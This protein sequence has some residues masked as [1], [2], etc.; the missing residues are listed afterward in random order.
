MFPGAARCAL[1]LQAKMNE[2]RPAWVKRDPARPVLGE[3][4]LGSALHV[5]HVVMG[6]VG[7][8]AR[9]DFTV[10]GHTVN[11]TAHLCAT[12]TRGE[13]LMSQ[14]LWERLPRALQGRFAREKRVRLK[15]AADEIVVRAQGAG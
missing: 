14:E 9:R 6:A 8:A 3:V 7:S 13:V 2:T 1:A 15:H 12:A 5:G 11:F 10:I 4:A